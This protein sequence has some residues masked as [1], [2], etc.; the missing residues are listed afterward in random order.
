MPGAASVFLSIKG[1]SFLSFEPSLHQILHTPLVARICFQS[2]LLQAASLWCA[3]H[4]RPD[5]CLD[6]S[7]LSDA[8][9]SPELDSS[10]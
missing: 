7:D 6:Y 3:D 2:K 8:A 9:V 1:S 4:V 10:F 5:C